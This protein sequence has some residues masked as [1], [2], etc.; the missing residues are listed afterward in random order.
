MFVA[1]I[2]YISSITI[3]CVFKLFLAYLPPKKKKKKPSLAFSPCVVKQANNP[4]VKANKMSVSH[5]V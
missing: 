2:T 3:F 4:M 1:C 5:G